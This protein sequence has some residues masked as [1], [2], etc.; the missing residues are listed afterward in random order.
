M[1]TRTVRRGEKVELKETGPS[2]VR[3]SLVGE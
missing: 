2:S 3:L 1:A